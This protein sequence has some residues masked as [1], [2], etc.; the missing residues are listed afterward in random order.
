[1]VLQI[2]R[3]SRIA[4][5][6]GKYG[7]GIASALLF[8]GHRNLRFP[9]RKG[10]PERGPVYERMRLAIEELGPA[11][12]KF[13]QIMATRADILPPGLISELRKLQDHVK[14][15]PF[16]EVRPLIAECC[17]DPGAVFHSIDETPVASASIAQVHR[18]ILCDGTPVAL[19]IQRPGIRDLIETDLSILRSVAVQAE[20]V[21]PDARLYNPTGMVRDFSNQIRK[22]LDFQWEARTAERMRQ[23]FTDVPGIRFPKIYHEYSSSRILV[24]EFID[25]IRIDDR[26]G[27]AAQGFDPKEIGSRGFHAYRKMI[28]EDGFFHGDPHPGNLLVTKDGSIA[29]LDFGIAGVVR[30]EKRQQFTQFLIALMTGNTEL[31]IRSLQALGVMIPAEDR[32]RL[33]DDLFCLV[34]DLDLG[35]PVSRFSLAPFVQEL[36]GVMRRYRIRVP[37]DLMLLLKV[38]VMTLDTGVRLD[39]EFSIE[40]ELSPYIAGIARRTFLPAGTRQGTVLVLDTADALL[41]MPRYLDRTMRRFSAGSLRLDLVDTDLRMFQDSLDRASDKILIGFVVGS[42]VIGSSV[43]LAGSKEPL[44][45]YVAWV[46]VLGYGAAILVSF[47]VLTD[48]LSIR[49]RQGW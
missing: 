27:I 28:F 43:I 2:Q 33:A 15:L 3:V 31:M 1:M 9:D 29:V 23:N 37:A 30:P 12:V 38:L 5:I 35:S 34:Q 21:I 26:E 7:F 6:L 20:R 16:E 39:P 14:P 24:M 40:H 11:Y 42:L 19:K 47:Y 41:D 48:V 36:A 4:E 44:H 22:E 46:A 25:G 10:G 8:P 17:L 18:A 49:F 45:P 32:E 13:G